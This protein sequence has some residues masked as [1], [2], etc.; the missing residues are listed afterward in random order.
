MRLLVPALLLLISAPVPT[1]ATASP[2]CDNPAS[3]YNRPGGYCEQL[4]D[5]GTLASPGGGGGG[6]SCHTLNTGGT[7]CFIGKDSGG[8]NL[9]VVGNSG[10]Y[11]GII[12]HGEPKGGWKD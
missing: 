10:P 5:L 8:H 7:A 3:P 12:L 9:Y 2:L 11:N 4:A 6:G 1:V